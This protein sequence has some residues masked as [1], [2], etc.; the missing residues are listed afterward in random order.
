MMRFVFLLTGKGNYLMEPHVHHVVRDF[1]VS[2]KHIHVLVL[3]WETILTSQVLLAGGQVV[4]LGELLFS[5]H[6]PID[7]AQNE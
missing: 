5:P 3:H 2:N 4:F 1:L 6:L 7:L